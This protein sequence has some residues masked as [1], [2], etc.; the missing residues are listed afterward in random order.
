MHVG[1]VEWYEAINGPGRTWLSLLSCE[2]GRS[3]QTQLPTGLGRRER[4]ARGKMMCRKLTNVEIFF[5]Q[6]TGDVL[7]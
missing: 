5:E 4:W 1:D 2:Q 6:T 3:E 7:P